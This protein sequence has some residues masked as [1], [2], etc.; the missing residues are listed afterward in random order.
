VLGNIVPTSKLALVEKISAAQ[1]PIDAAEEA[2]NE[3][4][5]TL[6]SFDLTIRELLNLDIP[7]DDIS[8]ARAEAEKAV[9]AAAKDLATKRIAGQK[10]IAPIRAQLSLI[11]DS[12]E[13][14]IDYNRTEIKKMPIS[15]DS[16]KMDAQYFSFDTNEQG[17][18][19]VL[20]AVNTFVS[21]ATSILG[22]KRS[23]EF[24]ASV[25]TQLAQQR[26][27]HNLDGVLIITATCTH[28]DAALLAPFYLDV[29]KA[30]RVWNTVFTTD[31]DKIKP[32]SVA[33]MQ[34]IAAREDTASEKKLQILSGA[35]YGSSFVGM[36]HVLKTED[37][38]TSQK[39]VSLA[40]SL[41]GQ[42]ETGSW[43]ANASG[44]F[45]V[46]AQFASDV[47]AM[48]S[49]QL[50]SSNVSVITMGSIPSI[51]SNEV[52]IGVKQFADFD[53]AAMMSKLATLAN[54][55]SS[56]QKSVQESAAAA[57]TGSQMVQLRSAEIQS[58]MTGLGQLDDGKNK[59]LD[60]NS[61]MTA[62]EDYIDKVLAGNAGVP[63]NYYLKPITASE[64]AQMWVNKYFPGEY[65]VSA[66][67]DQPVTPPTPAP[68]S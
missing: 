58:V 25:Q 5:L 10:T 63:I 34:A 35:T 59:M 24:T 15:A 57:R 16:L 13:S 1:A 41:Q 47:K 26:E 3:A 42:M 38:Q 23:G 60:I 9:E 46:D 64:L 53:P 11:N 56:S 21:G 12:V 28:K 8:K 51:K 6:R 18:N 4:I 29:D 50:V 52:S 65:L 17:S 36:V 66:G 61:L 40:S 7:V 32:T 55:T 37:T 27:H 33:S 43:F 19:S 62:F 68:R 22:T 31:A 45:G 44:G 48:L 20:S 2:L 39:M 30:I 54:A 49:T 67:D 14:P